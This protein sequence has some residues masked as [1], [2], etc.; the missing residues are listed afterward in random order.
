[1]VQLYHMGKDVR[2]TENVCHQYPGL[3]AYLKTKLSVYILN[4][5]STPGIPQPN[6]VPQWPQMMWVYD[7]ANSPLRC[8]DSIH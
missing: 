2:E 5:R 7:D 8:T 4:G 1:M 6:T 3:V